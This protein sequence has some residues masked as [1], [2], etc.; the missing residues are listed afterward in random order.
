MTGSSQ[1][2]GPPNPKKSFSEPHPPQAR[3]SLLSLLP[4]VLIRSALAAFTC[5]VAAPLAFGQAELLITEI[6]YHPDETGDPV[7]GN[8]GEKF[9][10]IKNVGDEPA[11]MSNDPAAGRFSVDGVGAITYTQ[12]TIDPGGFLVIASS[13]AAFASE[14]GF[15]PGA[16]FA[17]GLSGKGE[18]LEICFGPELTKETVFEVHYWDGGDP[19]NDALEEELERQLWP[20]N[21]DEDLLGYT[22]VPFRPN[23]NPDPDDYRNWRP[24]ISDDG[25]SP[26]AD[27]PNSEPLEIFINEVR[28]RDA[29]DPDVANDAVEL[30]NPND[31]PVD[32]SNWFLTDNL[33]VP[34]R[35]PLSDGTVVPANGYLVLENGVDGFVLSLSSR[36]ERVFLYSAD[37]GGNLTGF[38]TGLFFEG[39]ADGGVTFSRYVNSVGDEHFPATPIS[40]G[41]AN[42]APAVGPVVITEIMY[43][44]TGSGGVDEYI[45]IMNISD[46]TVQLFDPSSNLSWR[47]EGVNYSL[48]GLPTMPPGGVA[49]ITP[50][51]EAAFRVAHPEVPAEVQIFGPWTS[52]SGLNNGGEEVALQRFE[53]LPGE[54]AAPPAAGDIDSRRIINV[55]VVLYDNSAPWPA[56][57]DGLG[58]SLVRIDP[59]GYGN[60]P[61]NWAPSLLVG[62]S[63]G[64]VYDYDGAGILVNE[65]LSHSDIPLTDVIEL[66]N[67]TDAAVNIGGW[68]LTDDKDIPDKFV[69]PAGTMIPAKGFWVVNQDN[70]GL[71]N[72][73]AP[74]GY[75]GNA[76]QLS[77]QGDSVWLYGV[78]GGELNGYRHGFQFRATENGADSD[79][80]WTLGRHVD[81][82]GREHFT[83]QVRSFEVNRFVANP[84]GATNNPPVVG[85]VVFTE[86]NFDPVEGEPEFIELKNISGSTVNLF[87]DSV[88]GDP[89]NNW[90]LDGVTFTFPNSRRTLPAGSSVIILPQGTDAADFRNANNV[91]AEPEVYVIGGA[92]GYVGALN[93]GG[94]ELV[95]LKPDAPDLNLTPHFVIDLVNYRDSEFWPSAGGGITYEKINPSGFSDDPINWRASPVAGGSPGTTPEA[96]TYALWELENFTP[97]ER[98]QAGLTDCDGD[99]NGDGILNLDAYAFGYDPHTSPSGDLLP[100]GD[101][102]EDSGSTYLAISFRRQMAA[103]DLIYSIETSTDLASWVEDPGSQVGEALENGDGT[104]TVQFRTVDAA[105]GERRRHL[106]VRVTKQ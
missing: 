49:L 100:S 89:S 32:I 5:A 87:D 7:N 28:T 69:I 50:T 91:P 54:S 83:T 86:I 53:I 24:S 19:S 52:G 62:G 2:S 71:D 29:D 64:V 59:D 84:D 66:Y 88:G 34:T 39:A 47:I 81:S 96:L 51:S 104:E 26:G 42:P 44:P 15:A 33:D 43:D 12:S 103:T 17:G 48:P 68:Y 45:E 21:P 8:E 67:P 93:N 20:S 10:E 6:N 40:L 63:P 105:D 46:Q 36:R 101:I 75:F 73:G 30:F 41:E 78:E 25:G 90:Q 35:F 57:A 55:D 70:D 74:A 3:M 98:A 61:A 102:I 79:G 13:S 65:V 22:L 16:T 27:E 38:V 9:I 23:S 95:L 77:S 99:I 37:A 58:R 11:L 18:Q 94:E 14:Y 72:N 56:E 85:P 31:T 76:F 82:F 60:D 80:G 97:E 92:D 4:R 1:Q 106:R